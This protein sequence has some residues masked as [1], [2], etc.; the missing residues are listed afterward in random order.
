VLNYG[1]LVTFYGISIV[2]MLIGNPAGARGILY[3]KYI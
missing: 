2:S 1:S 3:L